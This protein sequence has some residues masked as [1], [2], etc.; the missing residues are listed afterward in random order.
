MG[1]TDLQLVTIKR[2]QEIVNQ[3]TENRQTLKNKIAEMEILKV[4]MLLI[5][6][7]IEKKVKLKKFF[8]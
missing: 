8:T 6:R 3:L 4:K 7:F 1:D 5:K 2:L